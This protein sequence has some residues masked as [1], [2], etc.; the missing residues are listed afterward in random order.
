VSASSD[1]AGRILRLR[2]DFDRAYSEAPSG[3]AAETH[4]F[5]LVRVAGRPYALRVAEIAGVGAR[6]A[7]VPVP[8]RRP[9]L[10]GV[11]GIR[12]V[13]TCVYDLAALL[14]HGAA[15]G[16]GRG[17]VLLGE[18]DVVAVAFDELESFRRAAAADVHGH[19]VRPSDPHLSGVLR[20][21]GASRP[22]LNLRS[23]LAVIHEA[24][25]QP[26]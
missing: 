6:K 26:A 3:A 13:L 18:S 11:A 24:P 9:E 17:L 16:E 25:V 1:L 20:V 12:G 15:R 23:I 5:L 8:S 14:G 4:D 7:V 19:E 21:D 10:L 2:E 22:V